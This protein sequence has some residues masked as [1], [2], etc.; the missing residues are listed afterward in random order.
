MIWSFGGGPECRRVADR[1]IFG[2]VGEGRLRR[3]IHLVGRFS[4][5]P[6]LS[7][8]R[9]GP[10]LGGGATAPRG[11]IARRLIGVIAFERIGIQRLFRGTGYCV[12]I[13]HT[14]VFVLVSG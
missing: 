12:Q 11:A 10:S 13:V 2:F 14:V 9:F 3:A 1:R 7:A 5:F 8:T 4:G 6:R